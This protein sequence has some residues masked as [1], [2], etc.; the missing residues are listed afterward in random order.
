M[1]NLFSVNMPPEVDEP[2]LKVLHGGFITQGPQVDK[3][4]QEFGRYIENENV[5]AVNSGTSALTLALRI[6]GVGP[7]DQV[8]STPMTC[9]A[10]NLPILSLGADILWADV[11]GDTGLISPDSIEQLINPKV[12]AI[13]LCDW[14]GMPADLNRIMKLAKQWGIPVI[15]DAAHAVG[16]SYD[17]KRVG[18]I[19]DFTCFSFQAIKHMTTVDGGVLACKDPAAAKKARVLR[20]FGIDRAAVG[21]DSRIDQ[22]IEEWGYKFHMND[23]TATLGLVQLQHVESY[24]ASHRRIAEYYDKYLADYFTTPWRGDYDSAYWLYT[25]LLPTREER[26]AF[27]DHMLKAGIQVSQVHRRNDDYTVF[28]EASHHYLPDLGKN[29]RNDYPGLQHFADHMICIPINAGMSF[30]DQ[31][32]VTEAANAFAEMAQQQ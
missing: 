13:M 9:T 22:D 6:A 24:L 17:G 21:T 30:A 28:A 14:G 5:A 25:I 1:I 3:F 18:S 12:K 23:V 7:G 32:K 20:W 31:V 19:A 10:T 27:K 8:I 16:A 11:M 15:E 4:E 26:D 29:V 2:L